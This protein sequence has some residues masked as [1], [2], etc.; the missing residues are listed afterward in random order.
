MSEK[1]IVAAGYCR[2]S[3]PT[4]V[5]GLS[6]D[7]QQEQ[8]ENY[9]K[10]RGW[11]LYRIF[12]EPGFTAKDA[13][14]PHFQEMLRH[15]RSGKFDVIVVPK[16]DRFSRN[17]RILLEVVE[18]ELKPNNVQLVSV[19]EN[20][21]T[22]NPAGNTL[23]QIV[24]IFAAM[25]RERI[26][27]RMM[28]SKRKKATNGPASGR[29]LGYQFDKN[30]EYR[31]D[32]QESKIIKL[33]FRLY[34]TDGL[35]ITEITGRLREKGVRSAQGKYIGK[36]AVRY[37]LSNE[38]CTG[39]FVYGKKAT[40]G[41]GKRV[42]NPEDKWIVAHRKDLAIVSDSIFKKAQKRLEDNKRKPAR[43]GEHAG[44]ERAV[45]DENH[46]LVRGIVTCG[47]CGGNMGA[48]KVKAKKEGA[49]HIS[50][51]YSCIPQSSHGIAYCNSRKARAKEIDEEIEKRIAAALGSK[52]NIRAIK[53]KIKQMSKPQNTERKKEIVELKSKVAK[54]NGKLSR[55]EG[56][57][58]MT[59][60][61]ESQARQKSD[62]E[63]QKMAHLLAIADI[64]MEMLRNEAPLFDEN[65]FE[66]LTG[67]FENAFA[68]FS[69]ETKRSVIAAIVK[70]VTIK[71]RA[72]AAVEFHPPF[73]AL[74]TGGGDGK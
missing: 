28:D 4:Q 9:I 35:N 52:D 55:I 19:A 33:I 36:R 6:L 68:S 58:A 34:A 13:D 25:E 22:T 70:K 63:K 50:Y 15:L 30:G 1:E 31:I 17:I 40:L 2:V 45:T 51:V 66:A 53:N 37:I 16:I 3:T 64:E 47:V 27:E 56:L 73:D 18:N 46:L 61:I 32:E 71:D 10:S 8:V 69:S 44:D 57:G 72:I 59:R 49:T 65:L 74:E 29:M 24:G 11:K 20:I 41:N 7:I 60:L 42:K 39:R 5:D 54:I 67:N 26:V 62:L 23:F 38:S 12:V 48:H 21:D 14:R 43:E